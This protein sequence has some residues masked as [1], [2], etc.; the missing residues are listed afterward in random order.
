MSESLDNYSITDQILLTSVEKVQFD[1]TPDYVIEANKA[2]EEALNKANNILRVINRSF[3]SKFDLFPPQMSLYRWSQN[4]NAQLREAIKSVDDAEGR[5]ASMR[6]AHDH[7]RD[8]AISKKKAQLASRYNFSVPADRAAIQPAITEFFEPYRQMKAAKRPWNQPEG[9]SWSENG[10]FEARNR[11]RRTLSRAPAMSNLPQAFDEMP[12]ATVLAAA[13]PVAGHPPKP[14]KL[15]F[16]MPHPV[17]STKRETPIRED[18]AAN[19]CSPSPI[20]PKV[21]KPEPEASVTYTLV[22]PCPIKRYPEVIDLTIGGDDVFTSPTAPAEMPILETPSADLS[23]LPMT[24]GQVPQ[25]SV[26]TQ[27]PAETENLDEVDLAPRIFRDHSVNIP[28]HHS[29]E[30]SPGRKEG[31]VRV[32]MAKFGM[33]G[34][35]YRDGDRVIRETPSPLL[36]TCSCKRYQKT[37]WCRHKSSEMA[38]FRR[39]NGIPTWSE[40]NKENVVQNSKIL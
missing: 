18:V 38:E 6:R 26:A 2:C 20:L 31:I 24:P 27:L 19:I 8:Y 15:V 39:K 16:S 32:D 25:S 11:L 9:Q 35:W 1:L 33:E 23:T 29:P 22:S 36:R 5:L 37:F 3:I 7:M 10:S 13:T 34:T 4:I 40:P 28:E 30:A 12:E 14:E 21:I 17:T